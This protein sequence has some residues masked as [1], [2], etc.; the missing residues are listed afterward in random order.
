MFNAIKIKERKDPLLTRFDI[1]ETENGGDTWKYNGVLHFDPYIAEE[2]LNAMH[3]SR[4]IVIIE[5]DAQAVD[6]AKNN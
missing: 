4:H 3:H 1:Y 2:F 6:D 5:R